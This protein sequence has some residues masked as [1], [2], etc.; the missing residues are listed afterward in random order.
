M[1]SFPFDAGRTRPAL[2]PYMAEDMFSWS[3]LFSADKSKKPGQL[4]AQLQNLVHFV[5]PWEL[6]HLSAEL[7]CYAV[8]PWCAHFAE[9]SDTP[10]VLCV[11]GV[12]GCAGGRSCTHFV[13]LEKAVCSLRDKELLVVSVA[14]TEGAAASDRRGGTDPEVWARC[15]SVV[16]EKLEI[17]CP[18]LQILPGAV[19]LQKLRA[20]FDSGRAYVAGGGRGRVGKGWKVPFASDLAKNLAEWVGVV[21]ATPPRI[22]TAQFLQV[23]AV[24]RLLLASNCTCFPKRNSQRQESLLMQACSLL[25]APK[26]LARR[27]YM[28]WVRG[29]ARAS[30]Y[31]VERP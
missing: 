7:A 31:A 15:L 22:E 29:K 5:H 6:A 1:P 8:S 14:W 25:C 4:L 3:L 18:L 28:Y 10:E 9:L 26:S 21:A 11:P 23:P 20:G 13:A 19:S 16:K 12:G 17:E 24:R 30:V 2:P 27:I